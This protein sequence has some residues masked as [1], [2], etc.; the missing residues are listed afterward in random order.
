MSG[1]AALQDRLA[2][3]DLLTR[4]AHGV[5]TQ[6]LPLVASCFTPDCAY[7]GQLGRGTI[8]DALARLAEAFARYRTTLHYLGISEIAVAGDAARTETGCLA[9][10]V[11]TDGRH[12]L[13]GVRYGDDLVRT[14]DGW[15]ICRRVVRT[16]WL[17]DA[18]SA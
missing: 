8:A 4:Y 14:L 5:D 10:H 18:V 9:Y 2:L 17:L 12:L 13:A 6:D 3:R 15:R 1:G 16:F 7:E 11:R